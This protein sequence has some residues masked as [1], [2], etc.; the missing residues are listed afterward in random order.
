MRSNS[1]YILSM[2]I[3]VF[4]CLVYTYVV[5]YYTLSCCNAHMSIFFE[6][7]VP[8]LLCSLSRYPST[9]ILFLFCPPYISLPSP[10]PPFLHSLT[11]SYPIP[12]PS[13]PLPSLL[14][15]LMFDHRSRS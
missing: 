1:T 2:Y 3:H 13:L 15:G 12:I 14:H 9:P 11:L 5:P 7:P 10:H 8:H 6:T 4:K